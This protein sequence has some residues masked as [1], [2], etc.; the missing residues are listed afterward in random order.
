MTTHATA[1]GLDDFVSLTDCTGDDLLR[2]LALAQWI[3]RSPS[4]HAGDLAGRSVIL[5]FEKP[6]LRTRVAFEVGVQRLGGHAIYF[7]HS[8]RRIGERESIHDYAKNLE[9]MVDAIV[10]R[11]F[12]HET[13]VELAGHS[14]VPVVNALSDLEHPCQAL[15]D[16]LTLREHLGHLEGVTL[17]YVGDGN[18]VCHALALAC[19]M[20]GVHLRIITPRSREAREDIIELARRRC[21]GSSISVSNDPGDVRGCDAVYTDTWASMGDES[22]EHS[23]LDRFK[24]Y[25]VN[26]R[27]MAIAGADALFMHCLPAHRGHEVTGEVIDGPCSIVFDQAENR[28][29]TQC[30]LLSVLL[31]RDRP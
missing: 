1:L 15:A 22:D 13:I 9:R 12:S 25:Q 23:R 11:T 24:P 18:N 2:I 19:A 17:S 21:C 20:L 30:A 26:D 29:H 7:D 14:R 4:E 8:G 6:S 10:A 27:L 28:V 5:L 3:K 31:N 16:M